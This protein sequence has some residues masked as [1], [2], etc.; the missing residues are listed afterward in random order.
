VSA[1]ECRADIAAYEDKLA[2]QIAKDAGDA[3]NYI[4]RFYAAYEGE[5]K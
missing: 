1:A 4:E 3:G 5:E 2:Y